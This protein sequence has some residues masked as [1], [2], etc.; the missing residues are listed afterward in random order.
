MGRKGDA[1]SRRSKA[2]RIPKRA[3]N[4]ERG[5]GIQGIY[6]NSLSLNA[7]VDL[8]DDGDEMDILDGQPEDGDEEESEIHDNVDEEGES[9]YGGA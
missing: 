7:D 4:P 6:D 5:G 8:G 3:I 1:K 2:S 9:S